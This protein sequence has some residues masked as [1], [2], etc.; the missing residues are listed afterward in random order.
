MDDDSIRSAAPESYQGVAVYLGRR[1]YESEA[2]FTAAIRRYKDLGCV[3]W[4][5]LPNIWRGDKPGQ[6]G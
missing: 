2:A 5:D 6:S 3:V 1:D 4:T